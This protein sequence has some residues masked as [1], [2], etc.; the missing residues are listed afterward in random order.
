[1]KKLI[2]IVGLVFSVMSCSQNKNTEILIQKAQQ[3]DVQ[4]QY[5]LGV[6]YDNGYGVKQSDSQSVYWFQKSAEQGLAKA[7]YNLGLAYY[8]G[9]G[10][11]QSD[12]QA[13]YWLQRACENFND[14]A[15]EFLNKIKK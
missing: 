13:V 1:M 7:Q 3:G 2:L 15:C 8:K 11:K 9:V 14:K 10:V 5:D 4:A 12:S 6:A